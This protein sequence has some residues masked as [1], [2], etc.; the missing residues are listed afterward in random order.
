M[1]ESLEATPVESDGR[2]RRGEESR[3]R[4]AAAMLDLIREGGISPRAE[5]VAARADVGL[6]TVFRHFDDMDSLYQEIAAHIRA[7]ILPI[8][9]EPLILDNWAA[10][11]EQLVDKRTRGFEKMMPFR[12]ASDVHRERSDFLKEDHVESQRY[13][14]GILRS[15]VP[16]AL[17]DDRTVFEALDMILSFEAWRRLRHDQGLSVNMTRKVVLNAARAL[18]S[19]Y[20]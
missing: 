2:R 12:I 20:L 10:T 9:E 16:V 7:E 5:D 15:A 6:R 17:R 3:R 1:S 8:L 11:L 13:M 4:I 19:A 18:T 14:R